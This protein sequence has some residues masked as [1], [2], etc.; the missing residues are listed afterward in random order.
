[1]TCVLVQ[2]DPLLMSKRTNSYELLRDDDYTDPV[3]SDDGP[4]PA[5]RLKDWL[6]LTSQAIK[7]G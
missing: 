7:A 3:G 4:I 2:H 6:C 5:A 1:M